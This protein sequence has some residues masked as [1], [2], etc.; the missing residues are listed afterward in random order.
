MD[1]LFVARAAEDESMD[2]NRDRRNRTLVPTAEVRAALSLRFTSS[3]DP[4]TRLF[5]D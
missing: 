2:D 1:Y 3:A 5:W 4:Q